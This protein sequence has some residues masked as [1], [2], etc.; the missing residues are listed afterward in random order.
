MTKRIT[1]SEGQMHKKTVSVT[2]CDVTPK[3]VCLKNERLCVILGVT[4][5]QLASA[6]TCCTNPH[7][8]CRRVK[9]NL[10]VVHYNNKT[11]ISTANI[12]VT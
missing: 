8:H 1:I 2:F 6:A 9:K 5:T 4:D 11:N 7:I 12:V 10:T 3:S